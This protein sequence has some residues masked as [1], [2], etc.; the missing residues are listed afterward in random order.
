MLNKVFLND[1]E[2]IDLFYEMLGYCL[3]GHCKY[4]KAFFFYGE[5]SNGKS[6]VL[7][8]IKAFLGED[9][10]SFMGID[11]VTQQFAK[12]EL[13]NVIAN[14]GDDVNDT[15]IKQAG[16]LKKMITGNGIRVEAKGERGYRLNPTAKH[17]YTGNKIPRSFDK[18]NGFYR[19]WC[20]IPFVASFSPDDVDFDPMI[21][22]KVTT[23]ESLSYLLN[24]AIEGA[25]RLIK[26]GK[27]TSPEC[28]TETLNS[29][30]VDNSTTLL[31]V[32]E[33]NITQDMVLETPAFELYSKFVDRCKLNGIQGSNIPSSKS[34][35][36][37]IA[38]YFELDTKLKQ[39]G[40]GKR[41][42]VVKLD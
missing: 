33:D 8:M 29:Y 31:W 27:F 15:P 9:N 26:N 32:S 16:T 25:K 42:F 3:I 30:I 12:V 1:K 28:V 22:E 34:F 35:Y 37:E 6:T 40:D 38:K 4:Q 20:F 23:Q 24:K 13:E 18:T 2:V 17:I 10:L 21:D 14:I 39:R 5:G 41:Y 11:E 7:D 19:R 36:R